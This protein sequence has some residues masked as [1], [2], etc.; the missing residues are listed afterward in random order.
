MSTSSKFNLV[1]AALSVGL[2]AAVCNPLWVDPAGAID[3]ADSHG[4]TNVQ[5]TG[6]SWFGCGKGDLWHTKF[7]AQNENG[8]DISGVVCK[9]LFKGSTLRLD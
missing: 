7:T 9:G 4:F 5:T 6:Y 3:T 8:K 1:T 2:I